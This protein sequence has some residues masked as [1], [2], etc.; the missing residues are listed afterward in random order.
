M[1]KNK[2]KNI[3]SIEFLPAALEVLEK[4]PAPLGRIIALVMSVF[5]LLLIVWSY[6]GTVD[7]VVVAEGQT[8]PT[9]KAKVL[10]PLETGVVRAIHIEDGQKVGEGEL[11]M[12][13][14]PTETSANLESLQVQLIQSKVEAALGEAM[15]QEGKESDLALP[16]D[17]SDSLVRNSKILLKD[18][19]GRLSSSLESIEAQITQNKAALRAADIDELRIKETLPLVEERLEGLEGL[20]AKKL[21]EKA[22]VLELKREVLEM[23]SQLQSLNETRAQRQ[24]AIAALLAQRAET[25]ATYRANAA[26]R[27]QKALSEIASIEQ[28]LRKENQRQLYRNLTAPVEGYV[29]KLTIH[30][31]GAV[32]ET[33]Q[34][35]LTIVPSDTPLEIEAAIL[36]KDIGFV[37]VGQPAEIKLEAFPFTRY[38]VLHGKVKSLSNDAIIHEQLGPIYKAKVALDTQSITVAGKEIPLTPG[39]KTFVEIKTGKRKIIEFFLS[40]LLRYKDEAIR[41]R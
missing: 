8:Y 16:P 13:L 20:L 17:A 21:M 23:R 32:V 1:A 25:I 14:D 3:D 30:T 41:E 38:G 12:E 24:A 7:I 6:W 2:Q 36:N 28:S 4:P 40:P 35:L 34:Q 10:Q 27:R 22:T 37:E 18:S 19:V 39:M 31:I 9:G 29:D 26:D 33:G 5:F 15:L 11:L